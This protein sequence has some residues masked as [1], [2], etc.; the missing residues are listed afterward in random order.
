MRSKAALGDQLSV[1]HQANLGGSG[2]FSRSMYET[3]YNEGS[4]YV[5]LLDDDVLVE[6]EGMLRARPSPIC[7][8]RRPSSVGHMINMYVRSLLHAY[9]ETVNR[10]RFFW[11]PAPN[12]K[13][14]HDFAMNPLR[15]TRWLHRRIDV[16]YNGWWM[17]LIPT[18]VIREIGMSLPIFIKWDDA[19][20]GLRAR[21]VRHSNRLAAGR[22]SVARAV[23][24][25]GRH[26]RLAGVPPREKPPSRRAA[27]LAVRPRWA[28]WCTSR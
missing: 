5:L 1:I 13:H 10:F 23:D 17:C 9:G 12:S 28:H 6:P 27:A 25:Q 26:H 15:A 2:G 18:D 21:E 19:E 14:G 11:G 22:R 8:A 3:T 24:R 20:F 7:A 16:D 4:R